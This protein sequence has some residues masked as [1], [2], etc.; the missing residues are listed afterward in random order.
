MLRNLC[1]VAMFNVYVLI[2]YDINLLISHV[3]IF[4][5]CQK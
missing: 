1:L 5:F 4:I 3:V 2:V